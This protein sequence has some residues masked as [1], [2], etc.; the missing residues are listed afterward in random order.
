MSYV[1]GDDRNQPAFL[2][3][4]IE[5]YVEQTAPVRAIDAFV[6]QLDF[7]ALSFGRAVPA[8][9]GR[10]GYD[11]RDMLKLYVY[12]YLNEVRSSRRL[13]REC[14]RNL[15]LMWLVRRLAP[16]HK[17]IADFRR[18]NGAAIVGAC[19]AFVL[20]CR[21]QGL[22]A[23]RLLAIDGAKFRA[24]ASPIRVMDRRRIAEEA[25]KIDVRISSYLADLD[26]TDAYEPADEP[27][28][29]AKAIVA[30]KERRIDL[31]RLSARLDQDAR[32]LVVDGELDARRW[33]WPRREAAVI[34]CPDRGR[35]RH[36]LYRPPRSHRRG[37]RHAHASPD[38][39]SRARSARTRGADRRGR[40]GPL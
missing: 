15:E 23:A 13:E 36:R 12:G 25:E 6:N 16:D 9:I 8:S 30:L 32:S 34:Q 27:G 5:D 10:P 20:F 31:D 1:T 24:A 37:E 21:D 40:Y 17:T 3:P 18:D 35:R 14:R 4:A 19:R 11:P 28:A 7:S 39:K 33:V 22:F 29:T 2:P 26:K 38:R